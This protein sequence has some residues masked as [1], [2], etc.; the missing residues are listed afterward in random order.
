MHVGEISFPY[1]C[2]TPFLNIYELTRFCNY[3]SKVTLRMSSLHNHSCQWRGVYWTLRNHL[4]LIKHDQLHKNIKYFAKQIW[5]FLVGSISAYLVQA[6]HWK[7]GPYHHLHRIDA[8]DAPGIPLEVLLHLGVLG[9]HFAVPDQ[10]ISTGVILLIILRHNCKI[11]YS[12]NASTGEQL[13]DLFDDNCRYHAHDVTTCLILDHVP[14]GGH[15]N[16]LDLPDLHSVCS[17][18]SQSNACSDQATLIFISNND[19]QKVRK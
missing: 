16:N 2:I 13:Q 4:N 8:H 3:F 18:T 19:K 6:E 1:L 17:G 7:D 14:A 12:T 11:I 9:H 10:P 5:K 15:R